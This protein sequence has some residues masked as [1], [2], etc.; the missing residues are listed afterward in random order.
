MACVLTVNTLYCSVVLCFCTFHPVLI[1]ARDGGDETA[2][3]EKWR[4]HIYGSPKLWFWGQSNWLIFNNCS[5]KSNQS[6]CII[7]VGAV[8]LWSVCQAAGQ[9]FVSIGSDFLPSEPMFSVFFIDR[10]HKLWCYGKRCSIFKRSLHAMLTAVI[11]VREKYTEGFCTR[12]Q[13]E[14]VLC[15]QKVSDL[16]AEC[17]FQKHALLDWLIPT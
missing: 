13:D 12:V 3:L 6:Y 15:G 11:N 10:A 14:T 9:Y 5:G 8:D 17:S 7:Q 1:R 2:C 16:K 4:G